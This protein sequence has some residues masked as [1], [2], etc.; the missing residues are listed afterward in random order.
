MVWWPEAYTGFVPSLTE[1][2]NLKKLERDVNA[3]D[4]CSALES[5]LLSHSYCLLLHFVAGASSAAENTL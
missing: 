5:S 3:V 4:L 1:D 2:W